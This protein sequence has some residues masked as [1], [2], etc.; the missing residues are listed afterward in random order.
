MHTLLTTCASAD[1]ECTYSP[2]QALMSQN[3]GKTDFTGAVV[4]S[5]VAS[6]TCSYLCEVYG[7]M[8]LI[9]NDP[10]VRG[11]IRGLH[12]HV[13]NTPKLT[14]GVVSKGIS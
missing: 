11:G 13:A 7:F 3:T 4:K 12:P 9:M 2:L 5:E 8:I 14:Q 10:A 6:T 1:A